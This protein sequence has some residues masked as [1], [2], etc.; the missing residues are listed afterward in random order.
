MVTRAREMQPKKAPVTLLVRGLRDATTPLAYPNA[1]VHPVETESGLA[2]QK[3]AAGAKALIVLYQE[4]ET[5]PARA[6]GAPQVDD[7]IA[8][9]DG[10]EWL[11][12]RVRTRLNFRANWGVHSCEVTRTP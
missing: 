2:S 8:D 5:S 11:V 10:N 3:G 12:V 7:K 1:Y 6:S 4:G 9:A